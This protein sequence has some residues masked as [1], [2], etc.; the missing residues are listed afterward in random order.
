MANSPHTWAFPSGSELYALCLS[1]DPGE[2]GRGIGYIA[3]IIDGGTPTNPSSKTLFVAG[4]LA[5][6]T[7][8]CVPWTASAQEVRDAVVSYLRKSDT[9][10]RA[11]SAAALVAAALH[12]AWPCR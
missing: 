4:G 8:W 2:Q 11:F 7:Q 3:G 1:S 10:D 9:E 5:G 12:S 6:M